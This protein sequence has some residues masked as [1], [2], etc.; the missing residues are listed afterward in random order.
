MAD[1]V[2]LEELDIP[3]LLDDESLR[4]WIS[5]QRWYASKS[6]SVTGIEIVERVVLR[7]EPLLLLSLIQT[8]FATGTHEL[9]QLLLTLQPRDQGRRCWT[10]RD[11]DLG[12]MRG[13]RRPGGSDP[14]H[15]VAAARPGRR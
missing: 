5:V 7:E 9:Y 12:R 15:G 3:R 6:R 8:R 14:G 13:P 1:P 2:K 10:S 4:N 11:R